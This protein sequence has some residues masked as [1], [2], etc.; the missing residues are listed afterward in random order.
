MYHFL[1]YRRSIDKSALDLCEKIDI[2]ELSKLHKFMI[3]PHHLERLT[4][5][6]QPK[7]F[8]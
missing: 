2:M 8:L 7:L 6:K 1:I 5:W 3:I 4:V